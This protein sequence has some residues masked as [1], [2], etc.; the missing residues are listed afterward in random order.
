MTQDE[1]DAGVEHDRLLFLLVHR[2]LEEGL[3]PAVAL[4][5]LDA[6]VPCDREH[7]DDDSQ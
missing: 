6:A 1:L 2:A 3:H 7:D 4:A 5:L